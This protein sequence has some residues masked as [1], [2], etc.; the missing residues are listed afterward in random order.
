MA[1]F[2][3]PVFLTLLLAGIGGQVL[4]FVLYGL[5]HGVHARDLITT[6]GMPSSHTSLM[7]GLSLSIYFSEGATTG[8]F[9][10]LAVL[11]IVLV[12][13]LGVRRTVGEEGMILH[14]LI[15]QTKLHIKEP[16][17]SSGH[18]P[19]QVLAGIIWGAVAAGIVFAFL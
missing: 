17:Y 8:F 14:R 7:T 1:L 11:G 13:S 19:A 3:N 10:S 18:T 15:K 6:G 5:K 9:V 4:K 2:Q 12:D 16:H